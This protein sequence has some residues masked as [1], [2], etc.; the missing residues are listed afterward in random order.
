M[1]DVLPMPVPE[2]FSR[3]AAFSTEFTRNVAHLYPRYDQEAIEKA[4]TPKP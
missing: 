2:T 4:I 3:G 1:N